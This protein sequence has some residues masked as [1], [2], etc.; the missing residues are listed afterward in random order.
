MIS[1]NDFLQA[2][3]A[4][5]SLH[6]NSISPATTRPLHSPLSQGCHQSATTQ[7]LPPPKP[8][9]LAM[10]YT[11]PPPHQHPISIPHPFLPA[12]TQ[13]SPL[14]CLQPATSR[15]PRPAQV[16]PQQVTHSCICSMKT[17]T[18][19]KWEDHLGVVRTFRLSNRVQSRWRT[20]GTMLDLNDELD[21]WEA[22]YHSDASMCWSKVM[23]HWLDGGGEDEYPPTWEGLYELLN[24]ARC[25]QIAKKLKQAV[26]SCS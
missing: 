16:S 1:I 9:P 26:Q 15:S 22:Q 4:S 5:H 10:P 18:I 25:S 23:R 11:V 8:H 12:M 2:S 20:F 14:G 7:P 13:P 19:L 3:K 17:L 6:Y 24:D 21:S